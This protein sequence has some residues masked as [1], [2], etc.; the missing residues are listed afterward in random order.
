VTP[1]RGDLVDVDS[2]RAAPAGTDTLFLLNAV[3]PDERT[4]ALMT[5]SLAREAGVKDF[6]YISVLNGEEFVDVPH[7]AG[8]LAV[9]R[10]R[11]DFDA[12]RL[13]ASRQG[14]QAGRRGAVDRTA[15]PAAAPS[16]VSPG[17]RS[18]NGGGRDDRTKNY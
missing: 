5:L 12:A 13:P 4:Q 17:R 18:S 3:V 8:K 7:F 16:A 15:R 6:V 11:H 2:V 10:L 1:V 9:G 14:G